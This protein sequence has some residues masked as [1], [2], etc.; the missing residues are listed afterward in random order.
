MYTGAAKAYAGEGAQIRDHERAVV[1]VSGAM[2]YVQLPR[3]YPLAAVAAAINFSH[4]RHVCRD[5]AL[6]A[7]K[8]KAN[9]VHGS[10]TSGPERK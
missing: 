2:A 9:P 8:R 7:R 5:P 1:C 3:E 6:P 10:K 4:V